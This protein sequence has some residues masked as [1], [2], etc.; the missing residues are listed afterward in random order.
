MDK[1]KREKLEAA[2]WRIGDAADFL[3]LTE[4]E[5]RLV[6]LRLAVSRAVRERRQ[7]LNMTQS[8]VAA[9]MKSSQSR[10]A[11]IEAAAGVSLDLMFSGLFALGG[12]LADLAKATKRQPRRLDPARLRPAGQGVATDGTLERVKPAKRRR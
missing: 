8:Q 5:Q 7:K 11:N 9:K 3:G 10:V 12:S 4:E 2:G 6:E 1:K